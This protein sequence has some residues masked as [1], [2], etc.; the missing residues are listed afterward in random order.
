MKTRVLVII[1]EDAASGDFAYFV[2][3]GANGI[4]KFI[5]AVISGEIYVKRF[6][7]WKEKTLS[8]P[9]IDLGV[10]RLL[11]GKGSSRLCAGN[12]RNLRLIFD[13]IDDLYIH[14]HDAEVLG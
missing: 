10:E 12:L 7:E 1:I 5:K 9:E 14:V 2:A 3:N 8:G 13:T 6:Q 11:K 4:I